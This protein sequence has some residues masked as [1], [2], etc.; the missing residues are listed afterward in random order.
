MANICSN[1][2][3]ITGD[4]EYLNRL[5]DLINRQDKSL[6]SDGG[7]CS[8]LESTT[9]PDI[10]YGLESDLPLS[11]KTG[12]I[13]VFITSKWAPP[14]DEFLSLS[15]AFPQLTIEVMYEEPGMSLYGKIVYHNGEKIVDQAIEEFHYL[16]EN[17]EEF[18]GSVEDIRKSPYKEF[19]KTYILDTDYWEDDPTWDRWGYLLGP[20]IINRARMKDVPLLLNFPYGG[21][22]A[23]KRLAKGK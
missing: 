11:G 14:T 5:R 2:I 16:M 21:T 10:G 13:C 9:N 23:A 3:T 7:I 4:K 12:N 8:H 19:K 17:Y 6:V 20:L 22:L 1:N 15:K 18:R